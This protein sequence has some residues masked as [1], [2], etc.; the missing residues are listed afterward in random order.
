MKLGAKLSKLGFDQSFLVETLDYKSKGR[1]KF[2]KLLD[3]LKER[4]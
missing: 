2:N 3:E 4:F 1:I